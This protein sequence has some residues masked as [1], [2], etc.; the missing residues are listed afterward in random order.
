[1]IRRPPRSTLF[2]YTTLFRSRHGDRLEALLVEE[3]ADRGRHA[4]VA[5]AP[6]VERG[7]NEGVAERVHLDERR[8]A[9]RVA[10][11]V[12]VLALR[13]ARTGAGLDSD[14]AELLVL[15]GELVGDEREGEAREVRAAADRKSVV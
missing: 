2:P 10:E 12:D 13:E 3:L 14:H 6:R 15:A 1:M 9:D 4:V 11:V 5:E 7:R 8:E